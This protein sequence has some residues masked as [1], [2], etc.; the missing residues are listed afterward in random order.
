MSSFE[1]YELDGEEINVNASHSPFMDDEGGDENFPG[2]YGS[3]SYSNFPPAS[4]DYSGGFHAEGNVSVD[5]ASGS[6]E[7]FGFGDTNPSYPQSPFD[8]IHVENGNGYGVGKNGVDGDV[9]ASDGPVLPPPT[10]MEPEEGFALRE[11]RR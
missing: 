2:G 5:H 6:P 4:G 1:G 10:E 3:G 8:Q 11:W 9:F 7:I